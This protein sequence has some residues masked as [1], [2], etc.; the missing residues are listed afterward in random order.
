M[1]ESVAVFTI[2]KKDISTTSLPYLDEFTFSNYESP[3]QRLYIQ[4]TD[5]DCMKSTKYQSWVE[6]GKESHD[7]TNYYQIDGSDKKVHQELLDK[8]LT[9]LKN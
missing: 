7:V 8:I 2:N 9:W 4:C 6:P 3:V 5:G 1:L